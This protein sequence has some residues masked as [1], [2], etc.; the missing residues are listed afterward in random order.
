LPVAAM[1]NIEASVP[2]A[3]AYPDRWRKGK[4]ATRTRIAGASPVCPVVGTPP[5]AIY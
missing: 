5:P 1:Q 2:L 4:T 3:A